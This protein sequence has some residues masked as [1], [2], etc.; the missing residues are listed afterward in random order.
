M[1]SSR[2]RHEIIGVGDGQSGGLEAT[3]VEPGCPQVLHHRQLERCVVVGG[4]RVQ[5]DSH[6][7]CLDEGSISESPVEL[8]R[9]E[10]FHPVP[11]RDVGGDRLLGL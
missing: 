3:V 10:P 5:S 11:Q 6:Q 4:N 1:K 9:V 8:G 2:W 7:C